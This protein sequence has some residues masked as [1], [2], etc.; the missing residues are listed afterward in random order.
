MKKLLTKWAAFDR[1]AEKSERDQL[2]KYTLFKR[3]QN[4]RDWKFSTRTKTCATEAEAMALAD[5][6]T[7]FCGG[8]EVCGR[9][10]SS[11]GYYHYI[12]GA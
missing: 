4:P 9:T 2:A 1:R 6:I 7:Y 3:V 12:L 5:A 10:V 11:Q 8:A